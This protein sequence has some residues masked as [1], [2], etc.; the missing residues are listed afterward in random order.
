[1]K[2]AFSIDVE[3][4]Y[5]VSAFEK[6]ID[7]DSWDTWHSRVVDNTRK[8][9]DIL[10]GKS[11]IATFFILGWVAEKFPGLVREISEHGHEIACHGYSHKLIYNQTFEEF[12]KETIQ[13]KSLLE[14]I[15]QSN[16]IGYRAA[17][18]SITEKSMWALD[19]LYEAGFK[20]DSS[21]FPIYHDRY[22]IPDINIHPHIIKLSDNKKIAEFPISIFQSGKLKVPVSGGGYFR[23]FPYFLSRYGLQ[24]INKDRPFIF[25]IHPWEIDTEQP[26]INA[27]LISRFRHYNNINKCENRLNRL[28]EDFKF[29]SIKNILLDLELINLDV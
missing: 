16:V 21:I 9:L 12:R 27:S 28:L 13:S 14:D 17:S 18:F 5:H 8:M 2:N 29:T 23:L 25:Y 11:V 3:D 15:I 19:I 26:R 6:V 20:Y 24:H 1:M 10:S 22:G 7:R 4:Y